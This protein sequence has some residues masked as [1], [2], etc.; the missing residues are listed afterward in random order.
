MKWTRLRLALQDLACWASVG[1]YRARL[2]ALVAEYGTLK[3]TQP[4]RIY[5]HVL[6]TLFD[7]TEYDIYTAYI[8]MEPCLIPPL[9]QKCI[10]LILRLRTFNF[11]LT[12][13]PTK[14]KVK[15][16]VTRETHMCRSKGD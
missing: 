11:T 8:V 10:Q 13:R 16:V 14:A 4:M 7:S 9:V 15:R 2:P 12:F 1:S 5:S 3:L 6:Y